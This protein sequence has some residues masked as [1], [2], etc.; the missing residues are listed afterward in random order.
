MGLINGSGV[1][2][3]P[4]ITIQSV[5]GNVL[6]EGFIVTGGYGWD[7]GD[8]GGVSAA[9]VPSVTIRNCIIRGNRGRDDGGGGVAGHNLIIIDSIIVD[10]QIVSDAAPGNTAGAGGVRA[11][12]V[13]PRGSTI[14][15]LPSGTMLP[16]PLW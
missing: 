2:S 13:V 5:A 7:A 14:F 8:G 11:N 15:L 1:V 12:D 9:G 4:V 16:Q 3:Q 10:N 6:L